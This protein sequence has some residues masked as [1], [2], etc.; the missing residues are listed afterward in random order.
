L[1]ERRER[2]NSEADVY[3]S[4]VCFLLQH[5]GLIGFQRIPVGIGCWNNRMNREE[6]WRRRYLWPKVMDFKTPSFCQWANMGIFSWCTG[7]FCV[8][9][10]PAGVITEKGASVGEMP[11]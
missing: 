6:G 11:P 1:E 4:M 2:E 3:A 5:S 7:W 10:T 8:N 9:L